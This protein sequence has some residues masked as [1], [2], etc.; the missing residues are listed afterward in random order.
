MR[1]LARE[2]CWCGKGIVGNQWHG[3]DALNINA[4]L[5]RKSSMAKCGLEAKY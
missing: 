2:Y 5:L 4:S 3:T 1:R